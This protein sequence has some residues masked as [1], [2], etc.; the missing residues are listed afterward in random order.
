MD[1][2]DKHEESNATLKNYYQHMTN[3][4]VMIV[5][6]EPIT[7][8]VVKAFLEEFGYNK[9]VL[10][11]R[12]SQ[13]MNILEETG[14]DLLLLD[15]VMPEVSGFDI[16]SA[17]RA[18]PKFKHLPVII[19]TSSSDTENKLRA[20]DLGANDFLAK[21]LNK[22]ELGLRVRNT[23]AAKAYQDHL[24]YY[25]PLTG[26]PN[27]QL[28][29]KRLEWAVKEAKRYN[30]HLA[31]LTIALDN[32]SIISN[33]I[34]PRVGDE[35]LSTIA[36][37][38]E[39]V[40]RSADVLGSSIED[41][42][43]KMSLF[44]TE[45]SV[46]SLLL[47][48]IPDEKSAAMVA[49][50]II[51]IIR[52]PVQAGNS[53]I[54]VTASI[55]IATY[56]ADSGDS[57]SL[58]R[59]A[60]SARD[61]AINRGGNS[62]QFSSGDI[63]AKCNQRLSLET[64]LRRALESDELVLYYQPKV[65]VRQGMIQ[66]VEALLRW[67]SEAGLV[68]PNEF[69]PLAE[70]TGLIIPMGE[71][72]LNEAC[73]QLKKW[74]QAGRIPISMAVNL[75]AKQ[76]TDPGFLATAKRI[77]SNSGIDPELLKLELTETL[78]L[79]DIE[80]KI[81]IMKHLTDMGLKLSIDDFGTGYSSLRYL[82]KLPVDELKIDRSFIMDV[83]ENSSN[84]AIVLSVIFLSHCLGLQTVAEGVE[85]EEQ[86]GILRKERCDQYQGFLF[87]R[88]VPETDLLELLPQKD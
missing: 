6:D 83:V 66:G 7:I 2:L 8:E 4:T 31:L 70:E 50:R 13:A 58:M 24:V 1:I 48:R 16:L 87:S 10:V 67:N 55:G 33:T 76:F 27:M 5:D 9:F 11:E 30:D 36:R 84:R 32:F 12:S 72:V 59:L 46:Y 47:N 63:N 17:V 60:A 68:P 22:R 34:G 21:P 64:R 62:F 38:I 61:Y 54:T 65:D 53:D 40:I 51:K 45:S 79:E 42:E 41:D 29:L 39:Q 23:L 71:W 56:P 75:S 3:S 88:P 20:L 28:F 37:R 14:P 19:M 44:H 18:H 26:L 82:S 80:N 43:T 86:L 25:D 81:T 73:T 69:I 78:L 77:I 52:E 49:K 57:V 35:V 85:T 15:L 74:H